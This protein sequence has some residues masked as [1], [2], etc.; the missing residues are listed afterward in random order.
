MWCPT[1]PV[2][3]WLRG[4]RY[5]CVCVSAPQMEGCGGGEVRVVAPTTARMRNQ[6]MHA[7]AALIN[8]STS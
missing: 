4:E 3:W 2:G 1:G 7:A 6:A 5:V 8:Q